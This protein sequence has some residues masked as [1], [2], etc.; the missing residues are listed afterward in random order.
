M[1]HN[2][3][4]VTPSQWVQAGGGGAIYE[5][6]TTPYQE[7]GW[8]P[9][10]SWGPSI[11][12]ATA[13]SVKCAAKST[14]PRP[15][16]PRREPD[17][18]RIL[19]HPAGVRP[20]DEL[21]K[22]KR[23]GW[24]RDVPAQMDKWGGDESKPTDY[25]GGIEHQKAVV[26]STGE[27]ELNVCPLPF[28]FTQIDQNVPPNTKVEFDIEFNSPEFA[29]MARKYKAD[30]QGTAATVSDK[31]SFEVMV[32]K[33]FVRVF[34]CVPVKDI[35]QYMEGKVEKTSVANPMTF[36]FH[37]MCCDNYQLTANQTQIDINDVFRGCSP[38]LFWHPG[39]MHGQ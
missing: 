12:S 35:L 24:Y 29:L 8:S 23:Q 7:G 3:K 19:S 6:G 2:K 15:S 38:R 14:M 18:S 16:R 4:P 10:S 21:G 27:Y 31:V 17:L 5:Q 22:L 34:Y 39:R 36:P 33:S 32:D 28:N 11:I 20:W 26:N 25:K 13:A 9:S 1:R 37:L 30:G